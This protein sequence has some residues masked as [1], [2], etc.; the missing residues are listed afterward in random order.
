MAFNTI[1]NHYF[2]N[3]RQFT[4][5]I[6]EKKKLKTLNLFLVTKKQNYKK[7]DLCMQVVLAPQ[8]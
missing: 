1:Y 6:L 4:A 5:N 8:T 2:Q 7:S 3:K